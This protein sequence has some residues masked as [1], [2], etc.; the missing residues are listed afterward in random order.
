[1]SI[2]L[3]SNSIDF[4]LTLLYSQQLY[5]SQLYHFKILVLLKINYDKYMKICINS[6]IMKGGPNTRWQQQSMYQC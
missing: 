6:Q 1:M 4:Y 3:F 2:T 5:K